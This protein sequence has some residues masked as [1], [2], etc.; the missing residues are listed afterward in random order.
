MSLQEKP[1]THCGLF[2]ALDFMEKICLSLFA[3]KQCKRLVA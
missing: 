3:L 1:A 2:L